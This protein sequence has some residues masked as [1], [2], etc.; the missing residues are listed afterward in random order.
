LSASALARP[1]TH[2]FL[3]RKDFTRAHGGA[4]PINSNGGQ[5]SEGY[6]V[7]WLH[8][9]ELFRQ[10]R[11]EAGARQIAGCETAQFCATGGFREFTLTSIYANA[12]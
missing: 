10:L 4:L 1:S 3:P 2:D 6:L 7:G 9:V 8:H 11:G 5:L 12:L